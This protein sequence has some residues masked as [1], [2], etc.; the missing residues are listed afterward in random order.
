MAD[1]EDIDIQMA[2]LRIEEEE[3]EGFIL[4]GDNVDE[5]NRYELCLAGRLLSE[6]NVNVRAFKSKIADVWKPAMGINIKE[7]EHGMFLFQFFHK[8][9]MQW[10]HKGGPWS[11]D[12]I[13]MVLGAIGLGEDP[14]QWI[15]IYDLPMGLMMESVGKQL[16]NFFGEFLEYDTKNNSS[17]WREYM[18]V[19]V[20]ID[21]RKPLKRKKKIVRKDGIEIVVT[22]KYERLG[23]FCF[24]CGMVTHTERFCRKLI[25]NKGVEGVKEWDNWLRA[26]LKRSANQVQSKWLR[27]EDD[28]TWELRIGRANNQESQYAG[29]FSN[30][31]KEINLGSNPRSLVEDEVKKIS[32]VTD[33]LSNTTLQGFSN[34]S[35]ALYGITDENNEILQ[36]DERKRKRSVLNDVEIMDVDTGLQ[37]AGSQHG[38]IQKEAA[39][40][41]GDLSASTID[42][43]AELARQASRSP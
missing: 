23:E 2:G 24:S 15:Q 9:D 12:N 4:E 33:S 19:R 42:S 26:P 27:E 13:M 29:K 30:K 31:G 38:I 40:S 17:I 7:L 35:N 22:C 1:Y 34:N 18:R 10:V 11:F 3:N 28:D 32:N 41:V 43:S 16:G 25:D 6:R 36:L 14:T 20:R 39:I 37:N 21:V 5:I 8:E